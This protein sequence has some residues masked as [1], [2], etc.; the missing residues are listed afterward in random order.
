[1]KRVWLGTGLV[2]SIML[3]LLG[4]AALVVFAMS[5][6]GADYVWLPLTLVVA[7]VLAVVGFVRALRHT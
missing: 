2:V 4:G 7:S 1:V 5:M 6:G 3:L